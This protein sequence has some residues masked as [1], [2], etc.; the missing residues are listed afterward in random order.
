VTRS[1]LMSVEE[2]VDA[3]NKGC[4]EHRLAIE[5]RGYHCPA[6]AAALIDGLQRLLKLRRKD[7]PSLWLEA[8]TH[9]GDQ[10]IAGCARCT[11]QV[12]KEVQRIR[13]PSL[14]VPVEFPHE[15]LGWKPS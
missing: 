14:S 7:V 10:G 13:A 6:C 1:I 12:V 8:C 5:V 11:A 3:W 15:R 4:F 9:G 2:V